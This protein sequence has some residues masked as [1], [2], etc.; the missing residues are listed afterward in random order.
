MK[1]HLLMLLAVLFALTGLSM[2]WLSEG[3]VASSGSSTAAQYFTDPIFFTKVSQSAPLGFYSPYV[4][5]AEYH[6]YSS[7]Q[8]N[9]KNVSLASMKWQVVST[10]WSAT[11]NYAQTGSS[12]KVYRDGAWTT[13]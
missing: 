9:F 4:M 1:Q 7:V 3:Y 6:P 13:I 5:D 2:A 11:M 10:N 12:F 8:S